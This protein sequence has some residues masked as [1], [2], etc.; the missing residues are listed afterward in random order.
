MLAI[1]SYARI[2]RKH[3]VVDTLGPSAAVWLGNI[4]LNIENHI[5]FATAIP[6]WIRS[7]KALQHKVDGELYINAVPCHITWNLQRSCVLNLMVTNVR[8]SSH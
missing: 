5:L 2:G 3:P 7:P 1:T 8:S 4:I 6:Y